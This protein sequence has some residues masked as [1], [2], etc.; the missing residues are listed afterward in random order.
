M[1]SSPAGMTRRTPNRVTS[2]ELVGATTITAAANGRA[3]TPAA[4][5][6]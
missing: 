5:G 3:R 1:K 6:L 2:S 4:N